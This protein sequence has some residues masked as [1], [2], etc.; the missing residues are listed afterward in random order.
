MFPVQTDV[1]ICDENSQNAF[2]RIFFMEP[3]IPH[4][5]LLFQYV[6]FVLIIDLLCYNEDVVAKKLNKLLIVDL[7]PM[8][9]FKNFQATQ[10]LLPVGSNLETLRILGE[11]SPAESHGIY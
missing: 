9:T 11:L 8:L 1:F 10:T 7:F 2:I 4:L 6:S 3:I 5:M